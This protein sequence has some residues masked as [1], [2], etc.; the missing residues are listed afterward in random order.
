MSGFRV[1]LSEN[2]SV[3]FKSNAPPKYSFLFACLLSYLCSYFL[4]TQALKEVEKIQELDLLQG[5]V[6]WSETQLLV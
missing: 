1:S 5:S 4:F 2:T 6:G 3:C